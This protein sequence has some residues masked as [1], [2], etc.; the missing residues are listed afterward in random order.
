MEV[1]RIARLSDGGRKESAAAQ[2]SADNETEEKVVN[3]YN[4][5]RQ[6]ILGFGGAFT[7][8]A[9]YNYSL[10]KKNK[11]RSNCCLAKPALSTTFAVFPWRRAI[12]LYTC[13]TT[14]KTAV[15]SLT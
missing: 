11:K 13:T 6:K 3:V 7:D 15:G 1:T 10:L 5:T 4:A 9:A 8:S 2:F 14:L 12:F